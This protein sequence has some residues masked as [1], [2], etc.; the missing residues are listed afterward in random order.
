MN[1]LS[2]K[3][4]GMHQ[5]DST[6]SAIHPKTALKEDECLIAKQALTK[7]LCVIEEVASRAP[8]NT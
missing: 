2:N 7:Q 5:S 6:T 4:G 1:G 8:F 3:G